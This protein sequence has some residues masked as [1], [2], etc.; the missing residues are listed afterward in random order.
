ML[1][2][3]E[4]NF[5]LAVNGDKPVFVD[6]Y[7]DWCGPCRALT[8]LFKKWDE[9]YGEKA[10]FAKINI[11][12]ESDLTAR[13]AISS[14]PTVILF[15]DGKEARKWVGVPPEAQIIEEIK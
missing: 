12:E 13:F 1:Y 8:P 3:N 10:V 14:I 7:A 9:T 2:L 11:D 6:F 4:S 5:Q 15:R